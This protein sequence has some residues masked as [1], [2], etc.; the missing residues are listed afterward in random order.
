MLLT[1]SQQGSYLRRTHH[2]TAQGAPK[3][4]HRLRVVQSYRLLSLVLPTIERGG[5]GRPH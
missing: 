5:N 4:Y 3:R 1:H 2:D